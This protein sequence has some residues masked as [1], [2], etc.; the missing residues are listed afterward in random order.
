MIC[1]LCS[2]QAPGVHDDC[3]DDLDTQLRSIP[4]LYAELAVALRPGSA[5]GERVSG[6][7]TPP[8]P[9]RVEPL[10]LLCRGGIV[11][12][13]GTWETDWRELLGL[14]VNTARADR[15]QLLGSGR[16]LAGIVDFLHIVLAWAVDAHPAIDEFAGEIG[17]IISACRMALGLRSDYEAI[18]RCPA[19]LGGRT[20][21]RVLLVDPNAK[22]IR[23]DRCRTEWPKARWP[24]LATQI[25]KN[26]AA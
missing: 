5:G 6:T 24:L 17:D 7:R 3:L 8:L 22:I 26:A 11:S 2:R 18:G 23:C 19:P 13:L 14:P 15:E 1:P 9:L 4:A 16:A 10:S 20:C 12:I 25:A 21:G